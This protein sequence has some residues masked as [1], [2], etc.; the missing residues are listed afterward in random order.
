LNGVPYVGPPIDVWALGI[1]LYCMIVGCQPWDAPDPKTMIYKIMNEAIVF[2]PNMS[3]GYFVHK[4]K[5]LL[6]IPYLLMNVV[7]VSVVCPQTVKT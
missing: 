5:A 4:D 2:P 3:F 7:Y 1:V 6:I